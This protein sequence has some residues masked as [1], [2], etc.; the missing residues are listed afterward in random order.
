[1]AFNEISSKN[2]NVGGGYIGIEFAISLIL[3][4]EVSIINHNRVFYSAWFR[5]S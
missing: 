3:G 4:S 2:F 1:M 5:Y